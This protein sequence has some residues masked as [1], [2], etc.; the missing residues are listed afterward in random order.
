MSNIVDFQ[1]ARTRERIASHP[2]ERQR[3]TAM[4]VLQTCQL[5]QNLKSLANAI[6]CG[7]G[8]YDGDTKDAMDYIETQ[9]RKC[10][11]EAFGAELGSIKL[12]DE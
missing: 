3:A 2:L 8:H 11:R 5:A 6:D 9:I 4:F 1:Q 12:D 7:I 10:Y